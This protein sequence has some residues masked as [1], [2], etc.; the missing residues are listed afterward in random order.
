MVMTRTKMIYYL[1]I[2]ISLVQYKER[3]VQVCVPQ[4]IQYSYVVCVNV[5]V[6]AVSLPLPL[7]LSQQ[8]GISS[9]LLVPP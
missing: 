5:N 9:I 7:S 4:Y 1:V 8:R 3:Q 6:S 2:C